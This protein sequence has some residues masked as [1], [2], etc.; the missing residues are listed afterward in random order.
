MACCT[1]GSL[2]LNSN[3]YKCMPE[4]WQDYLLRTEL[5]LTSLKSY[6]L[7]KTCLGCTDRGHEGSMYTRMGVS[8]QGR[9][10]Q[11]AERMW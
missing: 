2:T 9:E 3:E 10:A 6:M 7:Y 8:S 5:Q 1:A 4:V 11:A